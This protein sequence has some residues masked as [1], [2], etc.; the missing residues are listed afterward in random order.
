[1]P[2]RVRPQSGANKRRPQF[3]SHLI[4][5][6]PRLAE[7]PADVTDRQ[8]LPDQAN[9]HLKPVGKVFDYPANVE[10]LL[11]FIPNARSALETIQNGYLQG[12][13]TLLELLDVRG[14]LLQA[15]LREQEALQNFHI[16]VATI[17]GLV[18]SPFSLARESSK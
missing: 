9:Q 12:R 5:A 17:E 16:A 7:P 2:G 10:T 18:G 1:M 14:S 4:H 11:D 8:R 15:L 13:F 6:R 3:E